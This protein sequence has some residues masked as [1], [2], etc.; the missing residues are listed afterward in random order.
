M[1]P[2]LHL[3]T[4]AIPGGGE[5]LRLMQAGWNLR[6]FDDLHVRHLKTPSARRSWRTMRLDVRNNL[7]VAMRYFPRH[8]RRQFAWDWMRRYYHITA[9][10]NQRSAFVVGLM[11]GIWRCVESRRRATVGEIVFDVE[12]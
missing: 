6:T 12:L 8:W 11:Q 7:I 2:W 1:K 3:D 4:A 5:S 9:K 10:K